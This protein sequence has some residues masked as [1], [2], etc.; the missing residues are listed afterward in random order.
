ML[1]FER[2]QDVAAD[3]VDPG[4]VEAD[5]LRSGNGARGEVGMNVVGDVGGGAAGREI[6]VVAQ[7]DALA[8]CRDRICGQAVFRESGEGDVVKANPGQAGGV[9]FTAFRIAVDQFDELA[10]AAH[11]VADDRR[12]FTPRGGDELVAD[13]ED[14]VILA[15]QESFDEHTVA[16]PERRCV[17]GFDAF[18]RRQI[19]GDALALISVLRLDDDG[20]AVFDADFTGSGPGVFGAGYRPSHR[21][22][23]ASRLQQCLRQLLVL[24]D[25]F[26]DGARAVSLCGLNPA[27]F[28]APAELDHAAL[29]QSA[30]GDVAR[31][32]S[33]DDGAGTRTEAHFLVQLAQAAQGAVEVEGQVIHRSA[34]E[35]LRQIEG[36]AADR[37]FA[38]L[39]DDLEDAFLDRLRRS[40]ERHRATGLRL[41]SERRELE[42]V[43][44]RYDVVADRRLQ[45]GNLR[46]ALAQP[47]LELRNVTDGAFHFAQRNDCLDRGVPAPQIGA[48]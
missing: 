47:R 26:G 41:Q 23:Y 21:N 48:A 32:R 29:G 17:S 10:N 16:D 43:R 34:A 30:E 18:A 9:A 45:Q 13:D 28:A 14:A 31:C 33:V 24:R 36:Q 15:W 4:D 42:R 6:G 1:L 46:E 11:A 3:E 7:D 37:L 27:L 5:H 39:D 44:H 38:V 22:G 25:R 40:A 8:A 35:F 2:T 12:R 20:V 19:H